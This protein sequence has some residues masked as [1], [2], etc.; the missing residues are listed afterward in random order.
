MKAVVQSKYGPVD[1]LSLREIGTPV[2]NDDQVLVRVR[3][4]SVHPDVWHVVT[5][6]PKILRLMGAGIRKP[7][8]PVPGTDLAGLVEAVGANVRRL[9]HG[10]EVFGE[11]IKG[12]QWTNGWCVRRIC[13]RW[14]RRTREEAEERLLRTS[15]GGGRVGVDRPRRTSRRGGSSGGAA[16]GVGATAVQVAKAHGA[17]VTGIDATDKLDMV[18]SLGADHVIDY[19]KQDFTHA[20]VKYDLIVDVP[21]NHSLSE[22]KRALTPGGTY[23]LIGHDQ[24]GASGGRWLG[25]LPRF[26]KLMAMSPFSRQLPAL[27]FSMPDKQGSLAV[28]RQLMEDGK[29]TPVIDRR[30]PLGEVA[31]VVRYLTTGRATGKVVITI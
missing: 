18:R 24:Y 30:Y 20:G 23:V 7:K 6:R 16:G 12:S 3:A 29:L 22:C 4:T 1:A 26:I 9:R 10:D 11:S 13:G 25:S 5:G 19:T 8:N 17:H 14:A 27:N 31:E 21:G 28:L 2:I 15:S